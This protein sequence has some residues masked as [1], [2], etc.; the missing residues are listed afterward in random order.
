MDDAGPF[1]IVAFA[2]A[3]TTR[4]LGHR[5]VYRESVGST[6]D[7][8]REEAASGAPHGTI[9]LAEEQTAGRGRR[10]RGFHSPAG[11]NIYVTFILRVPAELHR[12]LPVAVPYAVCEAV[13]ATG[14]DAR[15]KWPNDIWARGRKLSG[16]LIDAEST[17]DGFIA[18]PGI[19]LNVNGDPTLIPELAESATSVSRELGYPIQRELLLA[20]ICNDLEAALALTPASL[21]EHY[22][23]LSLI[24]GLPVTV[25]PTGG[26]PYEATAEGIDE[27]GALIVRTAAGR[28]TVSAADVSIRPAR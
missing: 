24:L 2:N 28:E 4:A 1:D 7:V 5:V 12:R 13:R 23:A 9:V 10:G 8:A 16:M 17:A 20:T 18:Y 3:L 27:S 22:R 11:Q 26:E 25:H 21:V 19:G 15:I 6:M 14:L